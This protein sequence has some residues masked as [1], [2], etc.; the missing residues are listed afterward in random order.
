M[1]LQPFRWRK[2]SR[3]RLRIVF[4]YVAQRFQNIAALFRE[5]CGYLDELAATVRLILISR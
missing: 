4:I 3:P 5:V 1:K 2:L